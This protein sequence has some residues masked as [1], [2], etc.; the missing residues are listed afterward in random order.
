MANKRKIRADGTDALT[1]ATT[2]GQQIPV[3]Y[4][5]ITDL[6]AV[7]TL[8]IPTGATFAMVQAEGAPVRWRDDGVAPTASVGMRLPANSEVRMDTMLSGLKFIQE[9]AGAKLNISYYG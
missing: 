8:T 1:V 4:Q 2:P 6:T 9:A 5:Q 3:G 7:I